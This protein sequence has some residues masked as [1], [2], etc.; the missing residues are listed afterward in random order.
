M[1]LRG[2]VGPLGPGFGP[3]C[4]P[5]WAL[6]ASAVV[7]RGREPPALCL[8]AVAAGPLRLASAGPLPRRGLRAARR[9]RPCFARALPAGLWRGFRLGPALRPSAGCGLPVRSALLALGPSRW[10]LRRRRAPLWPALACGLGFP[11]SLRPGEAGRRWR[12]FFGFRLPGAGVL[13]RCSR[14]VPAVPGGCRWRGAPAWPLRRRAARLRGRLPLC[15]ARLRPRGVCTYRHHIWWSHFDE[16][17]IFGGLTG[18]HIL[19]YHGLAGGSAWRVVPLNLI[20]LSLVERLHYPRHQQQ[21]EIA[22][23]SPLSH[24][25]GVCVFSTEKTDRPPAGGGNTSAAGST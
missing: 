17:G 22:P 6:G 4:R 20:W 24:Q 2:H 1:E 15:R 5:R 16:P 21:S 10:P 18:S 19:W 13:V 14:V 7:R 3:L 8:R 23:D 11:R 25:R 12:P 9:A